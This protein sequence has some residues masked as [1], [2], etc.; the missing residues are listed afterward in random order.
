MNIQKLVEVL[1][2][3]GMEDGLFDADVWLDAHPEYASLDREAVCRRA[4]QIS[5]G[6]GMFVCRAMR[7]ELVVTGR[8]MRMA[9]VAELNMTVRSGMTFRRGDP[10]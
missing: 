8:A 2:R 7:G 10:E 9:A 4:R 6:A 3:T 1:N 5:N